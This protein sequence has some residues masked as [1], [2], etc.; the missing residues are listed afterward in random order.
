MKFVD[1][2]KQFDTSRIP[3]PPWVV[4]AYTSKPTGFPGI[5]SD[6]DEVFP[7]D[8]GMMID[9]DVLHFICLIRNNTKAIIELVEVT[10]KLDYRHDV[11]CN[12]MLGSQCSC[13]VA[14]LKNALAKL[15]GE[16]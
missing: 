1:I 16:I 3:S 9:L 15:T 10:E 8:P 5:R 2:L 14:K 13:G 4:S 6:S 11:R 7:I 12:A